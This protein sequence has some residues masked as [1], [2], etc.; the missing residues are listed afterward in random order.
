M[1][2]GAGLLAGLAKIFV[3]K[4]NNIGS[5]KYKLDKENEKTLTKSEKKQEKKKLRKSKRKDNFRNFA[6]GALSGL[7]SPITL[8]AGGVGTAVA[9]VATTTASR[10]FTSKSID[11]KDKNIKGFAESLKN[12][13]GMNILG[14]SIIALTAFSK[15]RNMN[16][17]KKNLDFAVKNLKDDKTE[18]ATFDSVEGSE[19]VIVYIWLDALAGEELEGSTI[20]FALN[21]V[22]V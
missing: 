8:V 14:S 3:L 10:F 2:I 16:V 11:K 19:E 6:T 4:F 9:Y 18:L 21:F 22:A 7:L 13:A 15:G 20:S 5:K 17:L 1:A 12:N